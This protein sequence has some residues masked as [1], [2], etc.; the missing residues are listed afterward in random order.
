MNLIVDVGNTF[1]KAAV[2]QKGKIVLKEAME[3][4]FFYEFFKN[5]LHQF[6]EI[7]FAIV[8]AVGNFSEKNLTLLRQNLKVHVLSHQSQLPFVNKY[9]TPQTL[10]V[11][12]L[13]LVSAAAN[14]YPQKNVLIIDVGSCIT[15]DFIDDQNQ[16][17]GG[18]ISPGIEMRYRAL[19][20]FTAKLPLLEKKYPDQFIGNS[21]ENAIHSGISQAVT[22]EIEGFIC[23][24]KQ[25]FPSFITI[26][27]GGDT[28]F[29]LERIKNDI[30]ANSNFL[31]EGLNHILEINIPR[32]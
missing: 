15:Y 5:L 32:C 6:P 30:F 29:L 9:T 12:R 23:L 13:A 25:L 28:H 4:D 24:Y 27:T 10:G 19:H 18:A 2:F 1:V 7:K 8:S 14:Q 16:Y 31:L 22:L 3:H 11:D 21:T 20:N 26:L 17:Q